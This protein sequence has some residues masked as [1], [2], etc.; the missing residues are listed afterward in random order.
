MRR[1]IV[2][3]LAVLQGAVAFQPIAR[4]APAGLSPS[5]TIAPRASSGT[6]SFVSPSLRVAPRAARLSSSGVRGLAAGIADR[7]WDINN[8]APIFT[9]APG[10]EVSVSTTAP[11][12]WSGDL[13]FVP[14]MM[15]D[16][17]DKKALAP[18]QGVAAAIDAANSGAIKEMV[19]DNE[20][21]GAPASSSTVR[22]PGGGKVKKMT[23]LGAGKSDK[24]DVKGGAKLGAAIAA[25]AKSEKA[26][27][28]AILVPASASV[29]AIEGMVSSVLAALYHDVRFK[30]GDDVEKAAVLC[31]LELL[32]CP[33]GDVAGA[34]KSAVTMEAGVRL[35]KDLVG[36]P[37]NYVTPSLLAE[38]ALQIAADT[39]MTCKI[40]EKDDC[41]KLKMGSY[42]A[43][44]QGAAEPPKFI[45]LIYKPKGEIKKKVAIVGK[46]L[47]FD[48]GGYNI[49]MSMMELMK[50]DMGGS[51]ATL[52]A[53]KIVGLMQPEGVE[54]HFIVASCE[55]M[56]SADAFRP[57]DILTASNGKTIE[58]GNTDAEGRLTLA[59]ALVYAEKNAGAEEIIDIAT[60]TGACIVSLGGQYAGM[61]S[62]DEAMAES[63]KA[64]AEAT[65][66]KMWQMPL[67]EEYG[68]MIKSK[69]ADLKNIG[70]KGAGSITAALFLKEFVDKAKWAHLDIA[71][72]VWDDAK[73]A[74]GYGAKVLAN[75]VARS[76]K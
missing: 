13:L 72:P 51:A 73:G 67:P 30:S 58:V 44:S 53:A 39:G 4:L 24:F 60:L 12:D 66:E 8:N 38:T 50:F 40:L 42:L 69:I 36:G 61:W 20:F 33:E 11:E 1:R 71:G 74:T 41:V 16:G 70:G 19:S 2:A 76:G 45:H 6:S 64:S 49:K 46:G 75:W 68:E 35:T 48:S 57:G 56:V 10:V 32:A 23:I 17:E 15:A 22:M 27:T 43:V 7:G 28:A 47:T 59:D 65:G 52:G 55:N 63:I 26:K 5:A 3:S 31:K 34:I 54:A 14:L 9:S 25:T 62:N 18:I 37:A 29:E 21:K